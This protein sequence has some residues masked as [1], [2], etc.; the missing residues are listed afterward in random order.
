MIS[1][2]K[3]QDLL[4][5]A[6]LEEVIGSY[7]ELKKYGRTL[8][9]QCP[10][11]GKSGKGKGLQVSKSKQVYKCFS[12][13]FGGNNAITFVMDTQGR[14]FPEAAREI[15]AMYNIVL[16]EQERPKGPQ[17]RGGNLPESFRNIQLKL[18][19][20]DEADQQANVRVDDDTE[21]I[22]DTIVA[23]TRNEYG[24]ISS[25]GDDMII[26]YYDLEGKPVLYKKGKGDKMVPLWRIRWQNP[27][28]HPDKNG[29][30]MKYSSPYGS[31]T[32]LFIPEAVR[33]IYKDGRPIKRLY[34]Q[35]GEKK[36]LKA[37]KHGLPSVG[38]MGI[39]AL[40]QHG[41]LPY[42][43]QLIVQRCNI[44]EVIF[45]LDADWKEL[46]HSIQTGSKVDGRP[47]SFFNAV[48]SFKE[49]FKTF[50]NLGHYL[51]I[52]FAPL[53]ENAKRDK[54]ID[55]L[56]AN[57]LKGNEKELYDDFDHGINAKDGAGKWVD[58]HKI[59]T[60]SDG[61][62]MELWNLQSAE[63]FAK[64][65]KEQLEEIKEFKIGKH[66][67]RFDDAGKLE[68]AQPLVDDEIFWSTSVYQ[69]RSG[70]E[71]INITFDYENA[72][73]FLRNRG[74][75]RIMMANGQYQFCHVDNKV[76]EIVEPFHVKDYVLEIMQEICP[77]DVRNMLYRGG[78]MY[79]GPES[80]SSLKYFNLEFIRTS[81]DSQ[82]LFFK[83]KYWQINAAGI[84]EKNISNL[85]YFVWKDK[86]IDFDAT[87]LSEPMIR[88][89][90]REDKYV[91][92]F[93]KE[94]AKCHFARFLWNASEFNWRK[95]L[96]PGTRKPIGDNRTDEE[97][98]E[99]CLH[100]V[101]KMT[102]IGYL[103]HKF[104]D[105]SCEKAVIAMDG[106][107][108]EVG[109]SNGRTG[110][111][112]LGFALGQMIP[113]AYIAGKSRSL[114]DD[115]FIWEEVTE[116]TDNV[117]LDDVRT[118]ID[119]E[120]FFPIITGR[121]TINIKGKKKFTLQDD[122]TPKI[123]LTTNHAINGES[124]SFRDRQAVIVFS[125][126][127]NEEHKPIDDF[128]INFFVEW[129]KEQW[130]YFYNF[131]ANCLQLYF[132]AR[133]NKWGANGSGLILPPVERIEQRRKR[134]FIGEDFLSWANEYFGV[135]DHYNADE[136]ND[137]FSNNLNVPI[138]RGELYRDFLD[139][140]PTQRKHT[141]A[142][143]FKKKIVTWCQFRGLRFNPHKYDDM[144]NP[145]ADDKSGGVENFTIA[146]KKF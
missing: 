61:K 104:R 68:L 124:S 71:K 106:K 113:Q 105:K 138:P 43:L 121:M 87:R 143:R 141:T 18:S 4:K 48:K 33:K 100:F 56:L 5:V 21:K 58:V 139:K 98:F 140:N 110:K 1:P 6:R 3:K 7:Y 70:N 57:S 126:F 109:E 75:G 47:W 78:R 60:M 111:S 22:V 36:A 131:M 120:F 146:N 65:Y 67:W 63:A 53:R 73:N 84:E 28:L 119:F 122:Q 128:G 35:E 130:N 135:P 99:T 86:I 31:G 85:E 32:H 101:S 127:Y 94:G 15:A 13:D 88:V 92:K 112:L 12:C 52:Y 145:G 83:N 59:T 97:R 76:V 24:H 19:G 23:G 142:Y 49:Y 89:D 20:L 74:Y 2:E 27:D 80:L 50:T 38:I 114:T 82:P 11:C 9:T 55:D 125:D 95:Y 93:S 108:S 29:N 41:R 54:G 118:N 136:V 45:V 132:L 42:D 64:A 25:T 26:W 102:A 91:V 34:I 116:K 51:E 62:L 37:S 81:Q 16:E 69:D 79:L 30:P 10:K 137:V 8:F 77:K 44:E 129:D 117:F 39:H 123:L 133:E 40:G 144:G 107:L 96:E 90:K 72:Y 103:L 115:P 66:V 46:S 134:Q 14:S 17:K